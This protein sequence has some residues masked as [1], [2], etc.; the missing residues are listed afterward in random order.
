MVYSKLGIRVTK[1]HKI[2]DSEYV[3]LTEMKVQGKK[4]DINIV[5]VYRS[6]NSSRSNTEKLCEI[7]KNIGNN[8]VIIGDIN[9]P[10]I[11]WEECRADHKGKLFL[12]A[13]LESGLQQL[14]RTPTHNKG[15]R[16]DLLLTNVPEKIISISDVGCLGKSDHCMLMTEF[17]MEPKRVEPT[18]TKL[19]W[20]RANYQNI[21]QDLERHD[22]ET[23]HRAPDVEAA[24]E[25]FKKVLEKTVEAN[26]PKITTRVKKGR[27]RWMTKEITR[28]IGQK[29]MAWKLA[30]KRTISV[31]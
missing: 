31:E 14:V 7:V 29:K 27:P 21:R 5:L 17:Y 4:N 1:T 13:A 20:N 15:N 16:L 18:E 26:V 10:G 19:L 8:S 22:W 2:G 9:L 12:E 11:N 30:K 25:T 28:L 3:Q 24:W 23:L 6:P